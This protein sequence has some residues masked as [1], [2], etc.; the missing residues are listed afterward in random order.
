VS[1]ATYGPIQPPPYAQEIRHNDGSPVP[2]GNRGG[3]RKAASMSVQLSP[4][5]M[6]PDD[7]PFRGRKRQ[8]RPQQDEDS[9]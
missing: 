4:S 1:V 3:R 6:H 5:A 7:I 2:K 8:S 9:N